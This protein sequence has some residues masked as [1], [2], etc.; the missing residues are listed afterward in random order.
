[1]IAL[2]PQCEVGLQDETILA[3]I[4]APVAAPFYSDF[5]VSLW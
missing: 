2:S 3:Q 4:N 1:M 5:S